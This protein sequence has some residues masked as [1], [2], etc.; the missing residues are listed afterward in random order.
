MSEITKLIADLKKWK[1]YLHTLYFRRG[2][3]QI[4]IKKD[5]YA[6]NEY[7]IDM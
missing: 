2:S 1:M 6:S 4:Q 7:V 5:K 3:I